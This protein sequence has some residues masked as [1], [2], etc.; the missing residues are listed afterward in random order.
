[1]GKNKGRQFNASKRAVLANMLARRA[2][3]SEVAAALGMDQTSV[4]HEILR[5]RICRPADPAEA[6]SACSKCANY[7][8]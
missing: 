5:N 3:A 7:G 2:K 6:K 1:M 8:A 4:S